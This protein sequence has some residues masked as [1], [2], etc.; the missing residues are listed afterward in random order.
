MLRILKFNDSHNANVYAISSDKSRSSSTNFA[1]R[2]STW[3]ICVHSF[4][5]IGL[6]HTNVLPLAKWI[7]E[8]F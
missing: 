3:I 2:A 6:R 4:G 1:F 5:H 7:N 8:E